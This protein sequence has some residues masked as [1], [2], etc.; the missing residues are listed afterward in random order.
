MYKKL[1]VRRLIKGFRMQQVHSILIGILSAI[2]NFSH[3][4]P[5]A[6]RLS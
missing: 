6:A 4:Q 2:G 3:R 5:L 1:P